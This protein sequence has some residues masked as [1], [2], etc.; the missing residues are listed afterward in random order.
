M[1][2]E[3]STEKNSTTI[4][5]THIGLVPEFECFDSCVKGWDQY[6]KGSLLKLLTEGKGQPQLKVQ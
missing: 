4:H 6:V 3:L 2:F 5:F 1:S